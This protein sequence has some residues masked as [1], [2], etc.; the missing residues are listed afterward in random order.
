MAEA[1]LIR[2][3]YSFDRKAYYEHWLNRFEVAS[4]ENPGSRNVGLAVRRKVELLNG[5]GRFRESLDTVRE[6]LVM[7]KSEEARLNLLYDMGEIGRMVALIEND[8]EVAREALDSFAHVV[9]ARGVTTGQSVTS[10]QQSADL[11][12]AMFGN[13]ARSAELYMQALAGLDQLTEPERRAMSDR[14][15]YV[16]TCLA[17]AAVEYAK[18]NHPDRAIEVFRRFEEVGEPNQVRIQLLEMIRGAK[19]MEARRTLAGFAWEWAERHPDAP[20]V[21]N[22]WYE[23][24]MRYRGIAEQTRAAM[25]FQK[26][27]DLVEKP[28]APA[29]PTAVVTARS[30]LR[31][32]YKNTGDK[33][34]LQALEALLQQAPADNPK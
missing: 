26:F 3:N 10:L 13:H 20:E 32:Y 16:K 9:K 23:I 33:E 6:I 11:E 17:G 22:V 4:I 7:T 8:P 15:S 28:G 5:L 27:V 25:A 30:Y 24:G 1:E 21:E 14:Q 2:G 18:A 29:D 12:A 19:E 31:D 34:K